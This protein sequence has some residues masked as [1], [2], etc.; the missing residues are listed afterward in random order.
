[1]LAFETSAAE[2]NAPHDQAREGADGVQRVAIV[3][4]SYFFR[5]DHVV[6]QAGR[7]LEITVRVEPG[8]IPHRFVLE[9][10]NGKRLAEVP[11]DKKAKTLRFDLPAGKY[12]FHCPNRLL[13]F[14]SHRERGMAGVLEVKE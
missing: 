1:M 12:L 3:G 8:V 6:V 5:P 11:L 14:K 7:G 9:T 10:T 2:P 4:G 13:L